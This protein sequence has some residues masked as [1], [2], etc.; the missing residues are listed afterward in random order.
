M[1]VGIEVFDTVRWSGRFQEIAESRG[2]GVALL[3]RQK[4]KLHHC[5]SVKAND[6]AIRQAIVDRYGGDSVALDGKLCGRAKAKSHGAACPICHGSGW[7][8]APGPLAG[9][10][11]DVWAALALGLAWME[12]AR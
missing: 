10:S 6:P 2:I 11:N 9:I 1:P 7:E 8:R 3:P 4:V 5:H 12:G